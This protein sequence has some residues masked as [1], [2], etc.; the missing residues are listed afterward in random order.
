[1]LSLKKYIAATYKVDSEK[2]S[3]MNVF[4]GKMKHRHGNQETDL[5]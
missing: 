2:Q 1:L 5:F 4:A 3:A